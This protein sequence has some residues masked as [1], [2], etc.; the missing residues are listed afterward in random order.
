MGEKIPQME[1]RK[2]RGLSLAVPNTIGKYSLIS[3]LGRGSTGVVFEGLDRIKKEQVA[4]KIMLPEKDLPAPLRRMGFTPK[5][6]FNEARIAAT[7]NHP[8]VLRI[9]DAGSQ[10]KLCYIVLELVPHARTLEDFLHPERRMP[11]RQ[12]LST[13][14]RTALA[15][16]HVHKLGILH[17]DIKPGNI[18]LSDTGEIKICDFSIS[19]RM[20]DPQPT[21]IIG[22]PRYM[23]P[24]QLLRRGVDQRSEVFSL[25]LVLYELLSLHHPFEAENLKDMVRRMLSEEPRPLL[26]Y[27]PD[28]PAEL[29]T[30]T[31][32]CLSKNPADRYTNA[33]KFG[34]ALNAVLESLQRQENT[35]LLLNRFVTLRALEFFKEFNAEELRALTAFGVWEEH[36]ARTEVVREG[37]TAKH[38]YL[39]LSGNAE[40]YKGNTLFEQLRPGDCFGEM[41][42][43]A[44][45]KR[46]ASVVAS[47]AITVAK[48]GNLESSKLPREVCL[49]FQRAC[50]QAVIQRLKQCTDM[51]SG[52][53]E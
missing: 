44:K 24:E 8:N 26:E 48:F 49:K 4:L 7:I 46:T 3:E 40:I 53:P 15:L 31:V 10:G 2:I 21:E 25:G 23:S 36:A 30:I 5:H 39:L 38:C 19:S 17:R 27:L 6:F 51:L 14:S 11:F 12:V 28:L 37:D 9:L 1:T 22:S 13:I 52:N 29:G 18:L 45:I 32:R 47:E 33:R 43:I 50:T 16:A 34:A 35:A 42:Y 41:A 20:E